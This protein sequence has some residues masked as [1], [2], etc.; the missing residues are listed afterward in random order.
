MGK[1]VHGIQPVKGPL[2]QLEIEGM[3]A[4]K[5]ITQIP[6]GKQEKETG[7]VYNHRSKRR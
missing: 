3:L 5:I 1:L 7:P 2:A 6:P 4:G